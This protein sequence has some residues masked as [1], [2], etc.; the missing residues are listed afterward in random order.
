MT[1]SLELVERQSGE[2]RQGIED[3]ES[4]RKFFAAAG[5]TVFA[6][7]CCFTPMLVWTLAAVGVS[8]FT[9]YLDFVLFP[10]MAIFGTITVLSWRRWRA[11]ICVDAPSP[12]PE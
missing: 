2:S 7:L 1:E 8:A 10:A 11:S 3:A 6:A 5:G 4:K 9:P 12:A